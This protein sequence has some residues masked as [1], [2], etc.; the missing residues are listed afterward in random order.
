MSKRRSAQREEPKSE[1]VQPPTDDRD[2]WDSPEFLRSRLIN[3]AF[4]LVPAIVM[5]ALRQPK[6]AIAWAAV[7][8][9]VIVFDSRRQL[10][11]F[12]RALRS[13]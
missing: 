7:G 3:L 12:W 8:V 10:R 5:V 9:A 13:R 1:P 11:D 6:I 4:V 2:A